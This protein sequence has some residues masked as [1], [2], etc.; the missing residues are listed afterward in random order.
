[1]EGLGRARPSGAMGFWEKRSL[2]VCLKLVPGVCASCTRAFTVAFR[3]RGNW[4][5]MA[6]AEPH[7]F[8]DMWLRFWDCLSLLIS[9]KQEDKR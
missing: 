1:M 8:G 4:K 7:A 3:T 6:N 2:K 5:N 9:G